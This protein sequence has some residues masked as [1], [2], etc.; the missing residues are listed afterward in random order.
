MTAAAPT[1]ETIRS[2][3]V[4][5]APAVVRRVLRR[6]DEI[7]EEEPWW[8]TDHGDEDSLDALVRATAD[9]ALREDPDDLV[10]R[11]FIEVAM[12]HG[13]DRRDAGHRDALVH[14]EFLLLRRA[15]R[16]DLKEELGVSKRTH[17]ASTR[18]DTALGH[19][20]IASLYGYHLDE[21][22]DEAAERAPERLTRE[23][24]RLVMDWP[25]PDAA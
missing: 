14:H 19:A 21:L 16:E 25:L 7:L 2:T 18:L 22:P 10:S 24:Q 13:R 20:E 3:L 9:A 5:G 11:A 8:S 15:L 1:L 6:W 12:R 4:D 17:A 23:W